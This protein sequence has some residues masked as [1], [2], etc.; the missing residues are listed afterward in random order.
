M[1]SIYDARR[2]VI[3]ETNN[4]LPEHLSELDIFNK[5]CSHTDQSSQPYCPL[6]LSLG[7][8]LG[9]VLAR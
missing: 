4:K 6:E 9:V 5:V 2:H 8:A 3:L 1:S 7:I